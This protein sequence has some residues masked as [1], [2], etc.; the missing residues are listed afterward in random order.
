MVNNEL[1]SLGLVMN[2]YITLYNGRAIGLYSVE[3][4]SR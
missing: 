2:K 1:G 3:G 4:G